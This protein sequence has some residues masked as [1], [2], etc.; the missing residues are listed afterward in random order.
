MAKGHFKWANSTTSITYNSWRSMRN[1]CLYD[2]DNAKHYKNKGITVCPQWVDDFDQFVVDMGER[3]QNTTLDR[4]NPDGN[5]E[6]TNCRWSD[7]REQ[8]NNKNTLTKITHNEEVKTIGEWAF[9]LDLD[10]KELSRAYKRH[11]TYNCTTYE[12]LF[13]VGSLLTRRVS[14]R[15]NKCEV[16]ENTESNKW[17]KF[18]GLCNTCYARAYRWKTKHGTCIEDYPEWKNIHWKTSYTH[19]Q[20]QQEKQQGPE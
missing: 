8:Q 16:C 5:Y 10:A 19:Q 14:E 18:G 2:N 3:P 7:W 17:R 13:F 12:E 11:S 1:R 20:P 15:T 6:P 4:V 9:I